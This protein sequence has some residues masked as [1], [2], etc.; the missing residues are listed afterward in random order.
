MLKRIPKSDITIRP[1]K[2]HKTWN[3]SSGSSEIGIFEAVEG[4]YDATD[5][6]TSN[7]K[8]FY[9]N[10]L[11][12]QLKAQFYTDTYNP[13]KRSGKRTNVYYSIAS[14]DERYLSG[15]A[16]I[17]SIPQKYIG[18]GI[19]PQS[20]RLTLKDT[21]TN[22][23]LT[24]TDDGYSNIGYNYVD[25]LNVSKLDFQSGEF[26]FTNYYTG[27]AYS[28]SV[29]GNT[30]DL[31]NGSQVTI[32][33]GGIDY[34]TTF[35]SWDA[36]ATPSL[37]YLANVEFL[38]E[39][40]GGVPGGNVFY[41]HGLIVLTK[42]SDNLLN[43][44]WSL[45][46]KSTETIFEHEYLLVVNEDEF[47]VS[48]NP[49]A[50]VDVGEVSE[51]FTDSNGR[52]TKVVSYPGVRYVRKR[53]LTETGEYLDYSYTSSINSAI[54]GGFEQFELS[55]SIDLT[56]SFLAP[57]ITTIGLYNDDCELVAVAKLPQPIKSM[58][59]VPINFIVRFDT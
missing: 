28:V 49:T 45:S 46:F 57:F 23:T 9:K 42:N 21:S 39:P 3:F 2:A 35:Y 12:G 22:E 10:A 52:T 15:S 47:N 25:V 20:V 54:S 36:N 38:D 6:T 41:N 27:T 1:F 14:Q 5:T 4:A 7:G 43:T 34:T 18:D 58:P 32:T 8:T 48:T 29:D 53:Q 33:S 37:M 50:T 11:Y 59:D 13:F 55:A 26:N 24:F 40:A 51:M 17:I 56:G 31:E 19:K 16:K 44:T 30:W